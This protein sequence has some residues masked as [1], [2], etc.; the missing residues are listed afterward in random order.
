MK[1]TLYFCLVLFFG[2]IGS[3]LIPT[4]SKDTFQKP[5][6]EVKNQEE[7]DSVKKETKKLLNRY[8]KNQI[9]IMENNTIIKSN[10]KQIKLTHYDY[11]K[12]RKYNANRN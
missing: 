4:S 6:I 3:V 2:S 11:H 8:L 10:L 5:I 9:A 12:G 7:T 1:T